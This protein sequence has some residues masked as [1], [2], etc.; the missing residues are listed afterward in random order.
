MVVSTVAVSFNK[1]DQQ[2]IAAV[3][4]EEDIHIRHV[5]MGFCLFNKKGN[6]NHCRYEKQLSETWH[7]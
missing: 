6:I 3:S 1:R 5:Q 7:G 4:V 2:L